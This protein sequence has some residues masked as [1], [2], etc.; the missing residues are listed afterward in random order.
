MVNRRATLSMMGLCV[1]IIVVGVAYYAAK[2]LSI[3]NTTLNF[4]TATTMKLTS[5]NFEPNQAIPSRFT[6]DGEDISPALQWED[7]PTGTKSFVLIVHDPDAVHGDWVHWLVKNIPATVIAVPENTVPIGGTGVN[8]SF[9][10]TVWGGPCPPAGTHR[11]MF[12][13]YALDIE[14][15]TG[16]NRA[17]VEQQMQ[18]HILGKGELMATYQR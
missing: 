6:C 2:D 4:N 13:V 17:D 15:I 9:G 5:S 10:K 12:E 3:T 16:Q 11:Y 8:N 1:I 18:G 7:I 14:A